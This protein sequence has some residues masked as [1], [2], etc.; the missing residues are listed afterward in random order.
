MKDFD[1]Q[2][3][4]K[5]DRE[6]L[7]EELRDLRALKDGFLSTFTGAFLDNQWQLYYL[8]DEAKKLFEGNDASLLGRPLK[9]I[10]P[11]KLGQMLSPQKINE[12]LEEK[13]KKIKKYTSYLHRWFQI[14][15]YS[16]DFGIFIRLEDITQEMMVNR[17]LQLNE[18]SVNRAKDMVF[19]FMP[20]GHIIFVNMASC[21]SLGY[22][23]EELTKMK[24]TDIDPHYTAHKWAEFVRNLKTAGSVT[25]ESRLRARDGSYIPV[26]MTCN[27]M[28]YFGD[29]YLMVFAR[30]I[31][32]RKNTEKALKEAKAEAELYVDLM[33]HDINNLNQISTGYLELALDML[34]TEGSI[35]KE[36]I[37]LLSRPYEMLMNSSR[38]IQNVQK[39]RRERAGSYETRVM[40]IGK[41]LQEIKNSYTNIAGRDIKIELEWDGEC[42]VAANELLKDV[43]TNLVGN[44]I[45]HS[46]GPLL[47][48][49]Q[50]AVV[51]EDGKAYCRVSVEDNG[52]G[53]PDDMKSKLL[54]RL[55]TEN[56]KTRGKGFGLYLIKQL[57]DD[58]NGKFWMEDRVP[59]DH[60]KGARFVVMLPA[61][62]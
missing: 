40:D 14:S 49:I 43:F 22:T 12:I 4:L 21:A 15:A 5:I 29:E 20:G 11:R 48:N 2:T 8:N 51:V 42:Q 38:L 16:S 46:S 3:D 1:L 31:T 10:Y 30:D 37:D 34:Q 62:E 41:I 58:F 19:W 28:E 50:M 26:E 52:P 35:D 39:G 56:S 45:K 61:T 24:V 18:F 27:Y 57:V 23:N 44:S 54:R 7:L 9:E 36:H 6:Q 53:I 32:V 60:T 55:S 13:E 59:G 47:I 25:Y 33:G 17:L